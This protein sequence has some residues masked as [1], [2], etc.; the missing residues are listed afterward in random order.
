[1]FD[2]QR[3]SRPEMEDVE[4]GYRMRDAG[5]RIVLDAKVQ[6]THRKRWTLLSMIRSDFARR[7]V[8][9]TKL[10]LD[11]GEFFRPRGLSLGKRESI[12]VFSA[13][14]WLAST[15]VGALTGR[16]APFVLA[17]VAL[18]I[19]LASSSRLIAWLAHIKGNAFAIAAVP[20]H[21]I[22]NIVAFF[23]LAWGVAA[24]PFSRSGRARYIRRQ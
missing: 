16:L 5:L 9:W 14:V 22:Y 17:A 19:F 4:L 15:V 12:G 11:R 8:P 21:L 13:P 7:G 1:M 18:A 20:L 24:S 10:L 3:F 6:C 2:E 23:A